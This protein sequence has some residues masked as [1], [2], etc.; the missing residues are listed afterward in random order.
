[1][2]GVKDLLFHMIYLGKREGLSV[3]R[4]NIDKILVLALSLCYKYGFDIQ[5]DHIFE[6]SPYGAYNKSGLIKLEYQKY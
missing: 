3:R 6:K 1:M 5:Y 2:Y 4:A